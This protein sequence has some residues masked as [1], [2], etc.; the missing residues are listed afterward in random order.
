MRC[1]YFIIQG[2]LGSALPC[3][4]PLNR[5]QSLSPVVI[6][7]IGIFVV[8]CYLMSVDLM[9]ISVVIAVWLTFWVPPIIFLC[10]L[11]ALLVLGSSHP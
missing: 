1:V 4:S 3:V 2:V 10:S 9:Q 8:T 11:K 7:E 6:G 5:S